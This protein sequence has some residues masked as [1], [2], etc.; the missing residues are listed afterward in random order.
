MSNATTARRLF[1]LVEPIAVVTHLAIETLDDPVG[2]SRSTWPACDADLSVAA[3]DVPRS[4]HAW[5]SLQSGV[6]RFATACGP[7]N[8]G[9]V[10]HLFRLLVDGPP[11]LPE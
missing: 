11:R 5:V 2:R 4:E 6:G 1:E 3:S 10:R 8:L 7:P 9:E